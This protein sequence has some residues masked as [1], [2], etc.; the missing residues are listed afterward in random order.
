MSAT[1]QLSTRRGTPAPVLVGVPQA[2]GDLLVVP[3]DATDA[4][5]DAVRLALSG[6]TV[7]STGD[8]VEV[9][10]SHWLTVDGQ[11]AWSP[12][13]GGTS[14]LGTLAV[15]A[16][17]VATLRHDHHHADVA[18]GGRA[19]Y[20]LQRQ[21]QANAITV[22]AVAGNR[23]Q[24]PTGIGRASTA[25]PDDARLAAQEAARVRRHEARMQ[26]REH[27]ATARAHRRELN[28]QLRQQIAVQDAARAA[29]QRSQ[30]ASWSFVA[31]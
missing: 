27:R 8:R 3:W 15:P 25:V 11:A 29:A 13:P 12:A 5:R 24:P 22:P 17:A 18:V 6:A 23:W 9:L 14:T 26:R 7:L 31:D 28:S 2:Q 19:V 20:V 21:R 16:D 10:P 4:D 30:P 1:A